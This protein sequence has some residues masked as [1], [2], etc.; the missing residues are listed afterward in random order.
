MFE[1]SQYNAS[2]MFISLQ[3]RLATTLITLH[4][5]RTAILVASLAAED[6][7]G[8]DGV[9]FILYSMTMVQRQW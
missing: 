3:D 4:E 9:Y 1:K 5:Q 7:G 8:V 6:E 2:H